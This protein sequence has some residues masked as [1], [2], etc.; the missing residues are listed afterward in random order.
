MSLTREAA[1]LA[2]LCAATTAWAQEEI[3]KKDRKRI[4]IE[5][6]EYQDAKSYAIEYEKAIPRSTVKRVADELEDALAQYILVFRFKPA[7]KLKV[8][9]LD[10]Q[11]TYEQE[12][13]KVS[14]AGH[15]LP[16]TGYL[17]LKQLEFHQLIPTA[18][19]EAFH[20]YLHYYVGEGVPIPIW[21]NEGMAGYYE[22]MQRQKGTKKLDYKL[23]DNRKLRMIQDKLL[24]R[25]A[26]PLENLIRKSHEEF[27]DRTDPQKESLNYTQSFAVIYFFMQGMG[28]KPVFQFTEELKKTK[29]PDAATEKIFGKGL[30]KVKTVE[31]QWKSYMAQVKIVEPPK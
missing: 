7:E 12:G 30:K 9:F 17:V 1:A 28:G 15:F 3:G 23:I 22:V 20:Q 29:D 10:S 11:N 26:V 25:T 8:R 27:H 24:T 31:S 13:G 2:V 16:G 4:Q 6:G 14:T 18:Y 5:W 19:H 21:F